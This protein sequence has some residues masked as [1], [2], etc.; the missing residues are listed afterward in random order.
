MKFIQE[1]TPVP[2]NCVAYLHRQ[3]TVQRDQGNAQAIHS[4]CK[5][6]L[7][8][9]LLLPAPSCSHAHPALTFEDTGGS[10]QPGWRKAAPFPAAPGRRWARSS[11][12]ASALGWRMHS[13]S[14]WGWCPSQ[15]AHHS[16]HIDWR[17]E[18]PSGNGWKDSP[19]S[20]LRILLSLPLGNHIPSIIRLGLP[21]RF[22]GFLL[23]SPHRAQPW[24]DC[25]PASL[26]L[27]FTCYPGMVSYLPLLFTT[28]QG[29]G[30]SNP[31][32][33]RKTLS[34]REVM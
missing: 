34:H 16:R 31:H 20:P 1:Y 29:C 10:S 13:E 32:F 15:T 27:H 21:P 14:P 25:L 12:W 33:P 17:K 11:T 26:D 7:S 28:A 24:R 22:L 4:T 23:C 2:N 18:G 9:P 5:F 30:Q 3:G 8:T 6:P 19:T